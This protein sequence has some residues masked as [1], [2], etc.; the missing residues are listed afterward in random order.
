V[1][2]FISFGATKPPAH[3]EDG[4][5]VSSWNLGKPS[6]PN[7]A[8][9]SRKL[10]LPQMFAKAVRLCTFP[11]LIVIILPISFHFSHKDYAKLASIQLSLAP[12]E[13]F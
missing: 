8:V 4:D 12:S 6:L 11:H 3:P 10:H 1:L 13:T 7:A 2:V 5:G 9:C